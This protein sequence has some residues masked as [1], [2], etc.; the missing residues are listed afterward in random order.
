MEVSEDWLVDLAREILMSEGEVD[1]A[2]AVE[3]IA[4]KLEEGGFVD[5]ARRLSAD[6]RELAGDGEEEEVAG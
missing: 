1:R 4:G 2:D 5:S 3:T 6:A